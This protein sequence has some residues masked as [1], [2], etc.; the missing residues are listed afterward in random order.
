M[1]EEQTNEKRQPKQVMNL[2][3]HAEIETIWDR[4]EYK[5]GKFLQKILLK[6]SPAINLWDHAEITPDK[7]GKVLIADSLSLKPNK[8]GYSEYNSSEWTVISLTDK[9]PDT[10]NLPPLQSVRDSALIFTFHCPYCH[11]QIQATKKE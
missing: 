8:A 10:S 2:S 4:K 11:K 9:K 3:V 7:V 1:A 5:P 6:H